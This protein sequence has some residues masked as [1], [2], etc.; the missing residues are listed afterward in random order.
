VHPRAMR[1]SILEVGG[2]GAEV[3]RGPGH[4]DQVR[5]GPGVGPGDA[6]PDPPACAGDQGNVA[7]EPELIVACTGRRRLH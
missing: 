6:R 2:N 4:Q 7:V 3:G 5:P 1:R